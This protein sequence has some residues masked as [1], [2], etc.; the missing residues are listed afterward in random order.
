MADLFR[1]ADT[2]GPSRIAHIHNASLGL[3]AIVVIDNT[4]CGV[5]VGGVRMAP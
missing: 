5:A 3:K 1:F 4:A 2:L